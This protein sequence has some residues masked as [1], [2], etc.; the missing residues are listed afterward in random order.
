MLIMIFYIVK[1]KSIIKFKLTWSRPRPPWLH[2][3]NPRLLLPHQY[4]A[5]KVLGHVVV[6]DSQTG[7]VRQTSVDCSEPVNAL[8]F[9]HLV[10]F[11][12]ELK[13]VIAV[14]IC[15]VM[16]ITESIEGGTIIRAVEELYILIVSTIIEIYEKWLTENV[17]RS[18][19]VARIANRT[20]SQHLWGHVTSSVT[21]PFDTT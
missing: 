5:G 7:V 18:Q 4:R 8:V 2:Q 20:A 19:A 15:N 9:V 3:S 10:A 12:I 13:R 14:R 16:C 11:R 6:E 17:T 21:W 1:S